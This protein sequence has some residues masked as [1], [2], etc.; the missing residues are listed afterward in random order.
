VIKPAKI[1]AVLVVV[2]SLAGITFAQEAAK[3]HGGGGGGA[4]NSAAVDPGVQTGHRG[5]GATI[6]NPS[7]DPTGYTTFF[8]DGLARFQEVEQVS[9]AVNVGLGPRFILRLAGPARP[10]IPNSRLSPRG[11]H[12][13]TAP[14]VSLP[15]MAQPVKPASRSSLTRTARST[16]VPPTAEWKPSSRFQA[17]PTPALAT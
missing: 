6:I 5:T 17:V 8:D 9:K 13:E 3:N 14:R 15:P 2:L 12:R 1:T 16:R 4:G 11:S 10:S 7:S